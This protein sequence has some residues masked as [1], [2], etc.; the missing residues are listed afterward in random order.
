MDAMRSLIEWSNSPAGR[1][2]HRRE[3]EILSR[4]SP[5]LVRIK[6]I[7]GEGKP[8]IDDITNEERDIIKQMYITWNDGWPHKNRPILP[9]PCPLHWRKLEDRV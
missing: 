9:R 8:I 4:Q 7:T 6:K 3:M 1:E 2:S 5:T